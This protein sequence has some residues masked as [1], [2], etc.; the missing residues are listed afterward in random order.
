MSGV[1]DSK[2]YQLRFICRDD[3]FHRNLW[4][5]RTMMTWTLLVWLMIQHNYHHHHLHHQWN[6]TEK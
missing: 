2:Y 3:R 5:R 1:F 6:I 4:T